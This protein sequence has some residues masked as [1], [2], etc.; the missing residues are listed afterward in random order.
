MYSR[1]PLS[2]CEID[3]GRR[4]PNETF[5]EIERA[6]PDRGAALVTTRAL[7]RDQYLEFVATTTSAVAAE[8]AA[9]LV[10][11]VFAVKVLFTGIASTLR[12]RGMSILRKTD[13]SRKT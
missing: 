10:C 13:E 1:G 7:L 4:A 8:K 6:A 9:V 12:T 11:V 2:V 3:G 5:R